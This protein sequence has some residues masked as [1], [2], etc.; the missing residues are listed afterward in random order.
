MSWSPDVSEGLQH[1]LNSAAESLFQA[2]MA[3]D[4]KPA[5]GMTVRQ[6]H[7]RWT[8][9]ASSSVAQR[10][11]KLPWY[12]SCRVE[13]L[14]SIIWSEM[15][16]S[17][18]GITQQGRVLALA[19]SNWLQALRGEASSASSVRSRMYYF[20]AADMLLICRAKV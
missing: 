19:A 11:S 15:S 16:L 13:V 12:L 6:V 20:A 5:A 18:R 10:P 1:Q 3:A 9:A 7:A 8:S 2:L 4:S 14:D 17:A